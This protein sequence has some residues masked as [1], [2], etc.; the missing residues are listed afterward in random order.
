MASNASN[1]NASQLL[2]D[3]QENGIARYNAFV[4]MICAALISSAA[5]ISIAL[6]GL[7]GSYLLGPDKSLATLPVTGYNLGVVLA[8]IPAALFMKKVGRKFGFMGGA[9]IGIAG[10]IIAVSALYQQSF[11]VFVIGLITIGC[12]GSFAQQIRFAAADRGTVA[13]RPKAIS[14]VLLGGVGAAI[15]GP[16]LILNFKDYL[17]PVPFAGAFLWTIALYL[18]AMIVLL[19]LNTTN[20][21]Q[22]EKQESQKEPRPLLEIA[23]QPKFM[24]SLLCAITA[25]ALMS[26]V[27]TAAPLAMIACGFDVDDAT[28][29]IQWHVLAMFLPSFFTG[30]LISRFGKERIVATGLLI[31][32]ACA[33]V[34]LN[35]V[36]LSNFYLGLIL[37]GVGWNFGFIGATAMI[38]DTYEPHEKG[39]TQGAN[40]FLLFGSVAIASFCSGLSLNND[41]SQNFGWDFINW[42]VFPAVAIALLGLLWLNWKQKKA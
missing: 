11:V 18:S 39:K 1:S 27:M 2:S 15:I 35:G 29:G 12:S 6:G 40:D 37:L 36:E 28:W 17:A 32:I 31:L 21:P 8:A 24:I 14:M 33:V 42:V 22:D 13:F 5:P 4:Y 30:N 20:A 7:V 10:A 16:Q 26:Y 19:F 3:E 9:L 38:T 23:T 41:P 25:Y 34:F